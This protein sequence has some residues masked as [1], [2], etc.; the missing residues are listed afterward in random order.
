MAH[1]DKDR[2]KM[3]LTETISLLCQRGL[4]FQRELRVQGLLGIT[5]DDEVFLVP[6]DERSSHPRLP[7]CVYSAAESFGTHSPVPQLSHPVLPRVAP[8]EDPGFGDG[9]VSAA[10][11]PS[12][13]ACSLSVDNIREVSDID[14]L[15]SKTNSNIQLFG[16]EFHHENACIN[17]GLVRVIQPEPSPPA[18][19]QSSFGLPHVEGHER[20]RKRKRNTF[21]DDVLVLSPDGDEWMQNSQRQVDE[22]SAGHSRWPDFG[23][24]L[25]QPTAAENMVHFIVICIIF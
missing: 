5:V 4:T 20:K 13:P 21:G 7:V 15:D 24:Q 1:A 14:D 8:L 25:R 6:V 18:A 23:E 19:L 11:I 3:L 2:L 16:K 9:V 22:L 12:Q 10:G 17:D